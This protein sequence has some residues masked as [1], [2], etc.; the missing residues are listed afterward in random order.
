MTPTPSRRIQLFW[1][2]AGGMN[3]DLGAPWEHAKVTER[4]RCELLASAPT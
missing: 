2:R 3:L 4:P 1:F